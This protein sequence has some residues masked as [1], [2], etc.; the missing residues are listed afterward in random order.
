MQIKLPTID[1]K[2]RKASVQTPDLDKARNGLSDLD[3]RSKAA[4]LRD[5]AVERAGDL[6]DF[7]TG[8]AGDLR[9]FATDR[10]SGLKDLATDRGGDLHDIATDSASG[11][12]DLAAEGAAGLIDLAKEGA[13]S[14]RDRASDISLPEVHIPTVDLSNVDLGKA[15]APA[16]KAV[17]DGIEAVAQSFRSIGKAIDERRH[18]RKQQPPLA[19]TGIALLA[20]I[21]GG[22]ALM[23][24]MDP[25]KGRRRR[26]LL[27]AKLD[28]W[29][30]ATVE[31]IQISLASRSQRPIVG[32]HGTPSD[33]D[34]QADVMGGP[35]AS[36]DLEAVD[37]AA[38]HDAG[39]T[40]APETATEWGSASNT[41]IYGEAAWGESGTSEAPAEAPEQ[42]ESIVSHSEV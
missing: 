19:E 32:G 18:P 6:R 42:R 15:V 23:F 14:A 16:A 10:A 27:R 11:L 12:K 41:G 25:A 21:G 29:S 2:F 28:R 33:G 36:A 3:L 7:A 1:I 37:S 8:R 5:A 34:I 30:R 9:D 40:P 35:D 26:M 13:S 38:G 31:T 22:M 24:F 4:D 39:T 20:G 17:G